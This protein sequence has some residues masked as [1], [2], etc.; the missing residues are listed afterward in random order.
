VSAFAIGRDAPVMGQPDA[1]FAAEVGRALAMAV[2]LSRVEVGELWDLARDPEALADWQVGGLLAAA[3][4]LVGRVR[5]LAAAH[6]FYAR[7]VAAEARC[8]VPGEVQPDDLAVRLTLVA[9]L[10]AV[11][12]ADTS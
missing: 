12:A 3:W 7:L 2:D 11:Q 6:R 5:G 8:A 1:W 9:L 10:L 4:L